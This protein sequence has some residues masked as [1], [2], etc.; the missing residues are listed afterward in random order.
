VRH[1]A[2]G[3]SPVRLAAAALAALVLGACSST[4]D[5]S[6]TTPPTAATA[7]TVFRPSG[8]PEELLAAM[9]AEVTALS[10][11][12][13]D[14]NGQDEALARIEAQWDAVRPTIEQDHPELL[15]G[16]DSAMGQV[17]RSVERRRPADADKATRSLMALIAAA[18]D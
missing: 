10:E 7:T 12:L 11:R 17:Q 1:R 2:A 9:A 18:E 4:Y 8:T 16:F 3:P 6:A 13:V 14:D 15:A 5:S